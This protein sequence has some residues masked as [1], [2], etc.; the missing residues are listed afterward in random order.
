MITVRLQRLIPEEMSEDQ[1]LLY[2]AI[3]GGKR[4]QV[5]RKSPLTGPDGALEGPFNAMLLVPKIGMALQS[6]GSAIRYES[7]LTSR[8]R[9][10]SIL[11][12]AARWD[13]R[14]EQ[15]A[16]EPL[17]LDLGVTEHELAEIRSGGIPIAQSE[18]E[19]LSFEAVMSLISP[20]DLD[21]EMYD[22][23][24]EGLG[25]E[26]IFELTAL[27]GYYCTLALQLRVFRV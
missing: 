24:R 26:Q 5:A 3:A 2:D 8:V 27:V 1:K 20:G 6:L 7:S 11:M 19:K 15:Q 18:S 16:H 10:L 17:A 9:E 13:C 4:S 23:C 21:D 25:E 22:K 12:V 14:F